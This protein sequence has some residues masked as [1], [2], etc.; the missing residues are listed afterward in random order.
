MISEATMSGPDEEVSAR[1]IEEIR[2][3]SLLSENGLKKIEKG[4][5]S[6]KL[7]AEDWRLAFEIDRRQEANN[8]K[9]D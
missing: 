2:K 4:L 7:T 5:A 8:V 1:I 3:Q 9:T 6:G